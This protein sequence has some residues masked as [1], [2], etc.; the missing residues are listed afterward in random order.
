[1]H[2]LAPAARKELLTKLSAADSAKLRPLLDEL[3]RL[4]LSPSL[5]RHLQ[6]VLVPMASPAALRERVE[7]L[8]AADVARAFEDCSAATIARF[9]RTGAW[10]WKDELLASMPEARRVAVL[11]HLRRDVSMLGPAAIY[12]LGER[13]CQQ[14]ALARARAANQAPGAHERRGLRSWFAWTR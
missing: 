13:L 9:L 3:D 4:G 5:G 10:P 8:Q 14:A 1:V 2:S 7:R 6:E 11:G 12:V